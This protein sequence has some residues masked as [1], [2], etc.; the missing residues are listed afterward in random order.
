MTRLT[1]TF[2]NG[3]DPGSTEIVLEALARRDV[4]ATFFMVGEKVR[5]EEG[6][7]SAVRVVGEGHRVGNHTLT[8]Q[9][10]L[11]EGADAERAAREIGETRRILADIGVVELL[12][13]P[14]GHGDLGTHL[15]SAAAVDYLV[16]RGFTVVTWNCVPR[17]WE[18]PA[19]EWVERALAALRTTDWVVIV[20]HDRH[21]RDGA[22][23]SAF[24]DQALALGVEFSR[25]Y[26]MSCVPI[27][28]G[29]PQWKLEGTVVSGSG[30]SR[31]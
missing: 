13:R 27:L 1:L 28:E 25:D 26:P 6:R 2:D 24:L 30:C 9:T 29:I 22:E 5:Q 31:T 20:L 16:R 3:P 7:P 14:N 12:F 8:H 23:L 4:P 15:L 11:G 17:D 10:P 18:S 19:G 21:M